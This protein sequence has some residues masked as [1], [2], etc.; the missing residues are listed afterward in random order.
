[1]NAYTYENL[2]RISET[3]NGR[4]FRA[5]AEKAYQTFFA[6]KPILPLSYQKFNAVFEAG[7]SEDY[8]LE[9]RERRCRLYLLHYLALCDDQYL[10]AFEDLVN[11]VLEEFTWTSPMHKHNSKTRTFNYDQI[12]LDA[13]QT[14]MTLSLIYQGMKEKIS[15]DLRERIKIRLKERVIDVFERHPEFYVTNEA[16]NWIAVQTTGTAFAYFYVFPERFPAVEKRIFDSIDYYLSGLGE[17]GYCFEGPD[18]WGYGFGWLNLFFDAYINVFGKRPE[19]MDRPKTLAVMDYGNWRSV[20]GYRIPFADATGKRELVYDVLPEL[21]YIFKRNYGDM[22]KLLPLNPFAL[23][24]EDDQ[25]NFARDIPFKYQPGISNFRY[26]TLYQMI[27]ALEEYDERNPA[28]QKTLYQTCYTPSDESINAAFPIDHSS[29]KRKYFDVGQV[30]MYETSKYGFLAKGG[31]NAEIHNHNDVGNFALYAY[32][33]KIVV[34]VGSG[35]YSTAYFG[36]PAQRYGDEVFTCGS[37]AHSL[38]MINGK[39]QSHGKHRKAKILSVS[40]NSFSLD[41]TEAYDDPGCEVAVTY[42]C[43]QNGVAVSYAFSP[44]KESTVKVRFVTFLAPQNE[45]AYLNIGG[46]K[47]KAPEGIQ[48]TVSDQYFEHTP[49]A[50]KHVYLIDFD[51]SVQNACDL[52]FYF[53]ID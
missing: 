32:D 9:Q 47:L 36:T 35:L 21:T 14:S 41:I 12:D 46:V 31:C 5:Y 17:D 28:V 52:Q 51:F 8:D 43:E 7:T 30:F 53:Q 44:E 11:A 38:P 3:A 34:D 26:G 48:P 4:R 1:M 15:P 42:V 29:Q 40:E 37:Q 39:R 16:S 2:K 10:P 23:F 13:A 45:G 20:Y 50:K 33:E 18:Y 24:A 22:V 49:T 19:V 6:N 25:G 27:L